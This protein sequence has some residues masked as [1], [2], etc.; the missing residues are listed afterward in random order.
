MN[1]GNIRQINY[2]G[3]MLI[4]ELSDTEVYIGYS[5]ENSRSDKEQWRIRRIWQVGSVWYFGFPDGEQEFKFV[6]DDRL[7]YTYAQ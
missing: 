7:T 6:W 2:D 1:I 4:D 3:I 5:Q